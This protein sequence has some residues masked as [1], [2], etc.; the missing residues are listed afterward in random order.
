MNPV[1][2]LVFPVAN[3]RPS[4]PRWRQALEAGYF[5]AGSVGSA[6]LGSSVEKGPV[7]FQ[8]SPRVLRRVT[9]QKATAQNTAA[10]KGI[11][12]AGMKE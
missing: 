10:V 3:T 5:E 8:S 11:S 12:M 1:Y 6:S 4:E 7:D 9:N 2:P